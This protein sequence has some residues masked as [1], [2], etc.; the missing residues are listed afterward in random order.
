M[1]AVDQRHV[2]LLIQDGA[3]GEALALLE[4]AF[5]HVELHVAT[6]RNDLFMT[7]LQWKMLAEDYPPAR[8]ALRHLRDKQVERLS[9]GEQYVGLPGGQSDDDFGLPRRF[10]ILV[11]I[12]ETLGE[13]QSTC[14][15]FSMLLRDHP[16][17]AR[18]N[19]SAAL[20]AL[21]EAGQF[22]LADQYRGEPL[23]MLAV[24]NQNARTLALMPPHGAPRLAAELMNLVGDVRIGCAVL[25]GLGKGDEA[26][27]LREALLSGLASDELR[28]LAQRELADRGTISREVAKLQMDLDHRQEYASAHPRS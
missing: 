19:A 24:V 18:R 17:L 9:A 11:D 21:V 20:P 25:T 4:R 15:V 26:D 8:A 7:M 13:P 1:D 5:E 3:H 23:E 16:S 14:E 27:A 22:A 6:I 2:A 10:S 28:T 12:N